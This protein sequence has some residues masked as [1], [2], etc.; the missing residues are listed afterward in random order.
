MVFLSSCTDF[1]G[2]SSNALEHACQELVSQHHCLQV[3]KSAWRSCNESLF[4]RACKFI[5]WT[6]LATLMNGQGGGG[7]GGGAAA[8]AENDHNDEDDDEQLPQAIEVDDAAAATDGEENNAEEEEGEEE[9]GEAEAAAAIAADAAEEDD[10]AAA[11]AV[12]PVAATVAASAAA[13]ASSAAAPRGRARSA[14]GSSVSDASDVEM[15]K[16]IVAEKA[17]PSSAGTSP[18]AKHG[19]G[20]TLKRLRQNNSNA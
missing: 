15:W 10:G 1:F 19:S 4:K 3:L 16:A 14:P 8:A 5:D 7:G 9:D 17:N 6:T 13:A 11:A 12:A 2:L 20:G 18:F